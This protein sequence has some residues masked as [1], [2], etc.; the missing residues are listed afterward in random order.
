MVDD[1][2]TYV[3]KSL[4][5][6]WLAPIKKLGT[7]FAPVACKIRLSVDSVHFMAPMQTTT[8]CCA[9]IVTVHFLST[10]HCVLIRNMIT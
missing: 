1:T 9:I 8:R 7:V 2:K 6:C 5:R 10:E 4:A 3:G